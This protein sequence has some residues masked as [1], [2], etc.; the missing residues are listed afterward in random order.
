MGFQH[1]L[2][3]WEALPV[4]SRPASSSRNTGCTPSCED[5]NGQL[6]A[7]D[8]GPQRTCTRTPPSPFSGAALLANATSASGVIMYSLSG[9]YFEL[10]PCTEAA[11]ILT[12]SITSPVT[13]FFISGSS[14]Y[15]TTFASTIRALDGT[16]MHTQAVAEEDPE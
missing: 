12:K 13:M 15:R 7:Q 6:Q 8:P 3:Q 14:P 10:C 16:N 9:G 4:G 5:A 11:C 1:H 2:P